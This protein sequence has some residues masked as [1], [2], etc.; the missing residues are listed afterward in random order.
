MPL[1][2]IA[3]DEFPEN[4]L[5]LVDEDTGD[6]KRLIVQMLV[7]DALLRG[8][9]VV[10]VTPRMKTDVLHEL[11][12]YAEDK[13]EHLEVIERTRDPAKL[14]DLCKGDVCVIENMPLFFV[15]AL[16]RELV[17]VMN[18]LVHSARDGER[19]ILMTADK[20][21]LPEKQQKIIR[22]MSDGVIDLITVFVENRISRYLFIQ[23]MR[24][25]APMSTMLPYSVDGSGKKVYIDTRERYA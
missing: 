16:D 21:I 18:G 20:G 17:H 23:K 25:S 6:I 1:T 22:A 5:I 14:V 24:G 3:L 12:G 10:Y 9:K 19:M 11:A 15:D 4:S 2:R 13:L 7:S 8:N